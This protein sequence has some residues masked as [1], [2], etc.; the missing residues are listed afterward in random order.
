ML[1]NIENKINLL[2]NI[3]FSDLLPYIKWNKIKKLTVIVILDWSLAESHN[4]GTPSRL[5]KFWKQHFNYYF[6]RCFGFYWT[7]GT[8][9]FSFTTL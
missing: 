1:Q 8:K 5:A 7:N 2:F 9:C 3:F 4:S 6:V